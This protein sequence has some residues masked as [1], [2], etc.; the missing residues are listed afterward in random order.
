VDPRHLFF[1]SRLGG[2]GCV[3]CGAAA[4][5]RD[6]VPSRILL[7]DPLPDSLPVVKACSDC[8]GSFSLDEEYLACFLECVI[9]GSA[10]P[11]LLSRTKI[12]RVL[13]SK[14][15]L[16]ARIE[17]CKRGNDGG[18][19]LWEPEWKRVN[20]VILK[21]AKGHAAYELF[22]QW[23]EPDE[24]QVLPLIAMDESER[25]D[26]ENAGSGEVS[27]WPEIGTRAFM[28]ACGA[29]PSGEQCGRW[30]VVQPGR[31]RYS[32]DENGGV[33]VRIVLAEYLAC[34]VDWN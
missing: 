9:A 17:S 7:D 2:N 34:V 32:V 16:A 24:L 28:R 11:E 10:N 4:D 21:L 23:N 15:E 13:S 5:S 31:Y 33:L 19:L 14:K 27:G 29:E 20:N 30:I 8:N 6:H 22:P 25:N 26:F 12:K 18:A 3:Y 1:D